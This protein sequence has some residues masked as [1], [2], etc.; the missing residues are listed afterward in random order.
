MPYLPP[1][2]MGWIVPFS[3]QVPQQD[4]DLVEAELQRLLNELGPQCEI[5][6][7]S[8]NT[9]IRGEWQVAGNS[10]DIPG[11]ESN[12]PFANI[13]SELKNGPVI[14]CLHGG[15]YISGS[16]AMERSAT[17]KLAELSGARM[18]AV[19]YRLAPQHPFP[20]ALIDAILAYKY[21]INPPSDAIHEAIDPRKLIIAGD[22]AG[23]FLPSFH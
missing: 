8:V 4:K 5:P 23:V 21:L 14:L 7:I 11:F 1:P 20:A 9:V 12:T 3:F 2:E 15:G 22:S 13:P 10:K 19:D 6:E 16:P 17:L 18:F